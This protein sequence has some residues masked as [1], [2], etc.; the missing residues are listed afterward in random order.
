[1]TWTKRGL[2]VRPL[3]RG[4]SSTHAALPVAV[5]LHDGRMLVHYATRDELGRS[6][7]AC[8]HVGL[9]AGGAVARDEPVLDLGALGAFDD[10]GVT[11][12]CIVEHAGRTFLYYT[13]WSLG[14]TVPFYLFAGCAVA[15][16]GGRFERV[17]AAPILERNAVDPFLTASPWVLIEDGR[18]RM[19]YVSATEW[20]P[21]ADGIRHRYHIRYAESHDGLSWQRDG[22]VCIDF[23][24]ESEYAFGRPCVLRD[25]DGYA[26][27]YCVRGETYR[28]GYAESD[29]GLTWR[30]LDDAV[31]IEP[32]SDG[33]DSEMQAYPAVVEVGGRRVMFYNGNGYGRDG[34]GWAVADT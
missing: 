10:N 22:R 8:A 6:R 34:I 7:V 33:W 1:M 12:S 28:I 16:G 3:G 17:S 29:N 31:G 13:G 25:G 18:W 14:R 19:W 30:R 2:I 27:W 24:D 23:G 11:P 26:M 15:D 32:S 5:A 20:E 4:W 21:T 9:D